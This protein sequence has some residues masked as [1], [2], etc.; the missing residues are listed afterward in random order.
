MGLLLNPNLPCVE[1]FISI[2][3]VTSSAS[4]GRMQ[5]GRIGFTGNGALLEVRGSLRVFGG[6]VLRCVTRQ[7]R[8]H[9]E[10]LSCAPATKRVRESARAL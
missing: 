3:N 8:H 7:H 1:H 9:R 5:V 10:H 6:P 2:L 4:A